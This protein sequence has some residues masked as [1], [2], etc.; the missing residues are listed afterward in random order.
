[1]AD[2]QHAGQGAGARDPLEA[3]GGG[4][5]FANIAELAERERIALLRNSVLLLKQLAQKIVESI[6]DGR[7]GPKLIFVVLLEASRGSGSSRGTLQMP[8]NGVPLLF[9][10]PD[11]IRFSSWD[12]D[13]CDVTVESA[14]T[15]SSPFLGVDPVVSK[16]MNR[17][18]KVD[19]QPEFAALSAA[20]NLLGL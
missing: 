1:M 5:E 7:Q 3:H 20:N 11:T 16:R 15:S 2:R 12:S 18:R 19:T 14:T 13:E 4:R 6:F 17:V 9:A 10:P 8:L